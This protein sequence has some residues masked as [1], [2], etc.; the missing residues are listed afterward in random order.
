MPPKSADDWRAAFAAALTLAMPVATPVGTGTAPV[1]A[2]AAASS[3]TG[4]APVGAG[5]ALTPTEAFAQA[6][7]MAD[8]HL[9]QPGTATAGAGAIQYTSLRDEI[10]Q[11]SRKGL[12]MLLH[13]L[14]A[15]DTARRTKQMMANIILGTLI[16]MKEKNKTLEEDVK[17]LKKAIKKIIKEKDDMLEDLKTDRDA[18]IAIL[19]DK[20]KRLKEKNKLLKLSLIHI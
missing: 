14:P 7:D 19:Q 13:F 17:D 8:Q 10:A 20:N 2:G 18:N 4:T 1:G 5:A 16:T 12:E 6:F 9:Q 11:M 15:N 3:S